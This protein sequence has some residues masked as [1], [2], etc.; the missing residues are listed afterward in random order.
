MLILV[1]GRDGSG[2][3]TL[4]DELY[5]NGLSVI[6]VPRGHNYEFKELLQYAQVHPLVCDRSF[7]TEIV[8]RIFDGISCDVCLEFISSM[9]NGKT[10]PVRII[11]C[12]TKK[13]YENS[14][15]RGETNIVKPEDSERI[16]NIYDIIMRFIDSTTYVKIMPYDWTVQNVN[17]VL[18]FINS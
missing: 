18:D 5:N 15:L 17:D 3:S 1:E 2:K 6:K 9:L 11:Y 16:G 12:K 14:M 13:D 10:A 4:C 7:I 8:Y